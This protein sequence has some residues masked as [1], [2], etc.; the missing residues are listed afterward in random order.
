MP[1]R[2]SSIIGHPWILD[3]IVKYEAGTLKGRPVTAQ[4]VQF[5]KMP[6]NTSDNPGDPAAVV[7]VSDRKFYIR[8]D[9]TKEA[10]ETME[11]GTDHFTLADIKYKI[12]ILKKYSVCFL[13]HQELESCEFYIT[14]H[15]FTLFP[16]ETD[17]VEST[18]CNLIPDVR[19]MIKMRWQNYIAEL[20]MKE[21]SSDTSLTQLLNMANEDNLNVLKS[22][23]EQCLD[24][25]GDSNQRTAQAISKWGAA[26][27]K[28]DDNEHKHTVSTNVLQISPDEEAALAQIQ[29]F[30]K[31]AHV[32]SDLEIP[33][34]DVQTS[35]QSSSLPYSSTFSPEELYYD[36]PETP[37]DDPWNALQSLYVSLSSG[38]ASQTKE[39]SP[40]VQHSGDEGNVVDPDSST[41][42]LLPY[43]DKDTTSGVQE[44]SAEISPL[45]VSDCPVNQEP[46]EKH[47]IM[48]CK[49]VNPT[50][51]TFCSN[52]TISCEQRTYL[53]NRHGHLSSVQRHRSPILSPVVGRRKQTQGVSSGLEC[54]MRP[55]VFPTE[56]QETS[57]TSYTVTARRSIKRKLITE[58]SDVP[59][60]ASGETRQHSESPYNERSSIQNNLITTCSTGE[61]NDQV[62]DDKESRIESFNKL[63]GMA[64]KS[65]HKASRLQELTRNVNT[66]N[67]EE[68]VKSPAKKRPQPCQSS[69]TESN[70]CL[71]GDTR[72]HLV[73]ESMAK[74][75]IDHNEEA[76]STAHSHASPCKVREI[77]LELL[78]DKPRHYDG[79]NFQYKYKPH[80]RDLQA[81]VNAIRFPTELYEW[82]LKILSETEEHVP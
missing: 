80:S 79:T 31:D 71:D 75:R 67:S 58:D 28:N 32:T 66:G 14:V 5:V 81:R 59:T 38:S 44:K 78:T 4:V 74:S 73:T 22:L 46:P 24:L 15:N 68:Y 64:P 36:V 56:E 16:M 40:V 70:Y 11:R 27:W 76:A 26:S 54:A 49:E 30:Q 65:S 7:H 29:E 12:I 45:I 41:P 55:L 51:A 77:E 3:V 47:E 57:G 82:A 69:F 42:E 20:A 50:D 17:N 62:H 48:R 61:K 21:N 2:Q 63:N 53:H 34:P 25:V 43:L 13:E 18:N 9:I 35:S 23:A 37:S 19:K 6:G 1:R 72:T 10:K 8:A 33:L 39:S 60:S 52:D